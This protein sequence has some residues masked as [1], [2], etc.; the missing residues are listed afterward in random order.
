[1]KGKERR[2]AGDAEPAA[3]VNPHERL[4]LVRP[5]TSLLASIAN[6]E[7]IQHWGLLSASLFSVALDRLRESYSMFITEVTQAALQDAMGHTAEEVRMLRYRADPRRRVCHRQSR[8]S[9]TCGD[10]TSSPPDR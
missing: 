5:T 3:P 2:L 9:S 1:M 7:L 10:R 8:Q 6:F 4:A